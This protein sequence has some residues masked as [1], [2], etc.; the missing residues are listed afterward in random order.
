MG[1][2]NVLDQGA[3]WEVK[4]RL[5]LGNRNY[6]NRQVKIVCFDTVTIGDDCL[7]AADVHIYDHDHRFDDL[8]RPIRLQGYVTRPIK[9]G[10]NVWI[11]AKATVLKGVTIH[12]GAVIAANSV[13]TKDVPANA[14]VGGNPARVI[15]VRG[16]QK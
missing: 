10:N 14:I 9:I 7:I 13:V 12:D 4:G 6:F 1:K 16:S 5:T 11:G 3:D 15:K 8:S 2:D